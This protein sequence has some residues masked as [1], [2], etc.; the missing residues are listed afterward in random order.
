MSEEVM[1]ESKPEDTWYSDGT[2]QWRWNKFTGLT[3][4]NRDAKYKPL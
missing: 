2:Y 4:M 3:R 1:R